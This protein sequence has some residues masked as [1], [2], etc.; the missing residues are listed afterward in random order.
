MLCAMQQAAQESKED[1]H[2]ALQGA[3]MVFVTVSPRRPSALLVAM[4]CLLLS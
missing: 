4:Q 3:D 2:K 1:V